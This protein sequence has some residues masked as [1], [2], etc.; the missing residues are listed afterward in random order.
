MKEEQLLQHYFIGYFDNQFGKDSV[1]HIG[2]LR[3]KE[4][5]SDEIELVLKKV[6]LGDDLI[7]ELREEFEITDIMADSED[8]LHVLLRLKT[9][10]QEWFS[11]REIV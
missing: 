1:A 4:V 11:E 7:D 10:F 5:G 2:L 9:D 6:S 3:P 8:K